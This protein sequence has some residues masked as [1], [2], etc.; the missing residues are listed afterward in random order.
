MDGLRCKTGNAP[1]GFPSANLSKPPQTKP[2]TKTKTY[3]LPKP[4]Q[5]KNR[6]PVSITKKTNFRPRYLF[7]PRLVNSRDWF[8]KELQFNNSVKMHQKINIKE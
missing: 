6:M 3:P 7:V 1:L 5:A 8:V 2:K 4:P